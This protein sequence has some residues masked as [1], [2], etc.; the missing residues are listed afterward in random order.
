MTPLI[1][2]LPLMDIEITSST[3]GITAFDW[4]SLV[5]GVT[6]AGLKSDVNFDLDRLNKL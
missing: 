3:G 5:L 1:S 6:Q 4:N 2:V